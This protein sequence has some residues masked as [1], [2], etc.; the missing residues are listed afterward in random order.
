MSKHSKMTKEKMGVD[1]SKAVTPPDYKCSGC[2]ATNCKLWRQYQTFASH[3]ELFCANC[4]I[5]DQ[6]EPGASSLGKKKKKIKIDTDGTYKD[7]EF[8]MKCDQIGWLVPAVPTEEG[9]TYW[10]Y[11]S[12]PQAGCD[13]WT[14]IPSYPTTK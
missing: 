1:Y 12:I 10:G 7:E 11:T 2:S 9:D 8:R 3:I 13:W 5:K 6:S 4:A 14:R